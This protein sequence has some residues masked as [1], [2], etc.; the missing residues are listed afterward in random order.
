MNEFNKHIY[1]ANHMTKVEYFQFWRT[2]ITNN[3]NAQWIYRL[4]RESLLFY[5][6]YPYSRYN[7]V[8][9]GNNVS[10]YIAVQIEAELEWSD[11][12]PTADGENI[13]SD[14]GT[15]DDIDQIL[16]ENKELDTSQL[17]MQNRSSIHNNNEINN[18]NDQM[19][20]ISRAK[21]HEPSKLSMNEIKA[22]KALFTQYAAYTGEI[23]ELDIKQVYDILKQ[24]GFTYN[25][26]Y[27]NSI[28][29]ECLK[30]IVNTNHAQKT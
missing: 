23:N 19:N 15:D 30:H 27:I 4:A 3:Y 2:I 9:V 11:Y 14:S 25:T 20:V 13:M 21:H 22:C 16:K 10:D 26:T 29:T 12:E 28:L 6:I 1:R 17:D 8:V 24:L 5:L 18:P 7:E